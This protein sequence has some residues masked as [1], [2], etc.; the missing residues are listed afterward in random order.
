MRDPHEAEVFGPEVL[1][2]CKEPIVQS[3]SYPRTAVSAGQNCSLS[4]VKSPPSRIKSR[5]DFRHQYSRVFPLCSGR[6]VRNHFKHSVELVDR[7]GESAGLLTAVEDFLLSR[8][9]YDRNAGQRSASD[10]ARRPA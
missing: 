10:R 4:E 2:A 7:E 6:V 8:A 3:T 1:V 9:T 5:I